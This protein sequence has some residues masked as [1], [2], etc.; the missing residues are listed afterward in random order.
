[1]LWPTLDFKFLNLIQA[2]IR[3]A[4]GVS[5]QTEDFQNDNDDD[6]GTDKIDN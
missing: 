6:Y 1:M 5:E 3:R 2:A 4:L